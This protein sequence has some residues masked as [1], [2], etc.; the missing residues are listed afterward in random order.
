M[1]KLKDKNWLTDQYITKQRSWGHIAKELGTYTNKV[2]RAAESLGIKSRDK[3]SAQSI[4]LK[5]GRGTHP[6]Q[7][8]GHS[9][10]SKE[11]IS[12][13]VAENWDG[14]SDE[15]REERREQSKEQWAKMS[16]A[17]KRRMRDKATPALRKASQEGSKLEK[18]IQ[19]C[20]TKAGYVI[21]YHRKNLIPNAN[22]E[23]DIYIPE[24]ATAVEIDGPSHFL[25][26]YGQATLDKTIQSDNEKNG[27]LRYN[28]VM[29][30]RVAQT[31]KTLSQKAMRDTWKAIEEN[32]Q[33]ISKKMPEKKDRFKTIKV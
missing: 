21:E 30:L 10:E 2:R 27:L 22:L 32:L 3:A 5:S 33:A 14:L 11:K 29:V 4:A 8:K 31:R 1:E 19:K 24:L 25:P 20:L 23:I 26:I 18:Y 28:G 7:D 17:D 13:G 12:E 16:E 15:V 9:D 6:T